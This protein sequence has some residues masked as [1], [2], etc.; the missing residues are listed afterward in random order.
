ML[1]WL[2]SIVFGASSLKV[3]VTV[4]SEEGMANV[5][6]VLVACVATALLSAAATVRVSSSYPSSGVAVAVT[7]IVLIVKDKEGA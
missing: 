2:R 6:P 4:T 1:T 7:G 3:A 5:Q